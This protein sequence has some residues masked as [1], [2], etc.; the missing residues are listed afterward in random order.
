[1]IELTE[2]TSA[3]I[4]AYGYDATTQILAIK[5]KAGNKVYHYNEIPPDVAQAFAEAESIGKAYGSMIRGKY[6]HEVVV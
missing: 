5:F 3:V 4:C 1:M 6:L 2:C